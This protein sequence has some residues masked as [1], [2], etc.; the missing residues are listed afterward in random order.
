MRIAFVFRIVSVALMLGAAPAIRAEEPP[1]LQAAVFDCD[2]TPPAG[3]ALAYD[4]MKEAGELTLRARGVVL[5][6]K[7]API[8]L[9]AVDWIGIA[10]EGHDFFRDALAQAAGTT[11]ERVAVHALHQHDAPLC[12]F[13]A[14]KILAQHRLPSPVFDEAV[15][16]PLILRAAEAAKASLA[17]ARPVSHAGYGEAKVVGVASNRRIHG[18]D[19]KV[20]AVRYTATKDPAL[21]AEPEGVIDPIVSMVTLWDGE[22]PVAALSYYATHPQSYYRTGIA[23]PDF[24]GLARLARDLAVPGLKHIHFN[25]AGG[26]IGAGKYNDGAPANRVVLA[27][28]LAAGLE[29]AWHA[30]QKKPLTTGDVRWAVERATL[31]PA[32]HLKA[33]TLEAAL[34]DTA[35]TESILGSAMQLA[36]LQRCQQGHQI[37]I[38]SLRLGSIALLHLPGEL[39]VEYQLA[40]K[41]T[42]PDLRIAMAAYGDYGPAY[43]GTAKAYEEGGY[44][45]EPRSSFVA[46]EVESVLLAAIGRLLKE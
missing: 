24:P 25:G 21:R 14:G 15:T 7:D 40:A 39:F 23:N 11:R 20:R 2:A 13:S 12:D 28:R 5:L 29:A 31:P 19:G 1:L 34:R 26:N 32:A 4:P 45:T 38:S 6:G 43:I 35:A 17:S 36:W 18:P 46:P 33:E 10:N 30:T 9:C 27:S 37:E 16:R 44:E 22:A 42:R 3:S 8:V 41:A